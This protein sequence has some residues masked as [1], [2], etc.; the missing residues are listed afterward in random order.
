MRMSAS[1]AKLVLFGGLNGV[2]TGE[3]W[4]R[5]ANS[6]ELPQADLEMRGR[7]DIDG[8]SLNMYYM[9]YTTYSISYTIYYI[10]RNPVML[11]CHRQKDA[12]IAPHLGVTALTESLTTLRR[13]PKSWSRDVG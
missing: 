13:A 10:S 4:S 11:P 2:G 6:W 3:L 8:G 9:P 5:V 7:S 1:P 12:N